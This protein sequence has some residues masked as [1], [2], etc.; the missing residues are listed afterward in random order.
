MI[1][2]KKYLD[3][4]TF[5]PPERDDPTDSLNSQTT[6]CFQALLSSI[7]KNAS[8]VYP[9]LGV[10]LEESLK[11]LQQRLSMSP[12]FESLNLTEKQVEILLEEWGGRTSEYFKGKADEVK[13]LLIALANAAECVGHKNQGHSRHFKELTDRLERIAD[14]DDLTEIRSSLVN[15]VTELKNSVNQMALDSQELVARLKAEV[16]I[17]ETRLKAAE[18]LAF[19]DELTRVANRRSVE[20]R[21]HLNIENRQPFSVV[22]LDLNHFKHVNDKYGHVVGDK[23]LKQFAKELQLNTR[24]GDLVGRWG[25]DEFVV[26]LGC[27]EISANS[28]IARIRDWVF[29]KYTIELEDKKKPLEIWVD[30]SIGVAEWRTGES[31]QQVIEKADTAMYAEKNRSR[32]A[33]SFN[34]LP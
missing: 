8:Q 15:R 33:A 23:M 2:L 17:Y 12:T 18:H 16:S 13:E 7:G 25:G 32:R 31:I 10:D 19:R 34:L 11:G 24:S 26:V 6:E 1:S 28:H 21:V 4:E 9:N 14:L 22:M 30:A 27:D 3:M 29:G 20:E 5:E